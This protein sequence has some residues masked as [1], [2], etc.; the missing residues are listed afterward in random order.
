MQ[1]L[2][3][4]VQQQGRSLLVAPLLFWLAY[5]PGALAQAPTLPSSNITGLITSADRHENLLIAAGEHGQIFFSQD[6]GGHWQQAT[7][8]T[9]VLITA[10][11]I[12]DAQTSWA[13]GHDATILRSDDSAQTW[14]I[15]HSAPEDETPLLDIHFIDHQRGYAIG[16]YGKFLET[17]DG[18]KT[19]QVRLIS[20]EQDLHLNRLIQLASGRL[21]IAAERGAYYLSDD[22]GATWRSMASPYQGSFFGALESNKNNVLL[23]GLRGHLFASTDQGEQWQAISTNTNALLTNGL[24]TTAG[25]CY[26]SGMEGALLYSARCNG[27]NIKLMQQ[28]DRGGITSL[29]EGEQ[30]ELLLFG[31][32]GMRRYQP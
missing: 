1:T 31:E 23:F 12:Q 14:Q 2:S 4:A 21:L 15:V 24:I 20:E 3:R 27:D 5:A 28:P 7:S 18:G 10:I 19:W 22:A 11:H 9:T 26:L 6:R 30:G 8:P 17:L 25:D 32:F 16:G 13:V 29:L